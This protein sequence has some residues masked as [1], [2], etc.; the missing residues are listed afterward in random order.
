[1]NQRKYKNIHG[2]MQHH[3]VKEWLLRGARHE[4]AHTIGAAVRDIPEHR[5]LRRLARALARG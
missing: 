4:E 5:L 1:M 3:K 2:H